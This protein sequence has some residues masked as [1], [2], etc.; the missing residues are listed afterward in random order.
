MQDIV[1]I[2]NTVKGIMESLFFEC[3]INKCNQANS[4]CDTLS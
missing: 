2:M 4:P 1:D 3:K